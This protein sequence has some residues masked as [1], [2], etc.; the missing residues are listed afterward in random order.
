MLS[1]A[2]LRPVLRL[3]SW[4]QS[5]TAAGQQAT[6]LRLPS[7][8]QQ[9]QQQQE[10][11]FQ[12]LS[13]PGSRARQQQAAGSLLPGPRLPSGQQTAEALLSAAS[14]LVWQQRL[15]VAGRRTCKQHSMDCSVLV[16][17]T[18]T[19]PSKQQV[20]HQKLPGRTLSFLSRYWR[21][22]PCPQATGDASATKTNV[23]VYFYRTARKIK[24]A[25]AMQSCS[26]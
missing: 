5:Q 26:G 20:K 4:H 23:T 8:Q 13:P 6:G 3:P 9:Q 18:L 15:V 22:S 12:A 14:R 1:S 7:L 2:R 11:S 16:S 10:A 19:K 17:L 24:R 25:Q 21:H